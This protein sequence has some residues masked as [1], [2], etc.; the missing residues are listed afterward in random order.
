MSVRESL[1]NLRET[2]RNTGTIGPDSML[3]VM[4]ILNWFSDPVSF[5][6]DRAT[7]PDRTANVFLNG[8]KVDSVMAADETNGLV[9]RVAFDSKGN[10]MLDGG[11]VMSV[12]QYGNVRIV[13][14][15]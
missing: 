10:V 1:R 6:L 4:T 8:T 3:D 9:V 7:G 15:E 11:H 5:G 14:K 2:V 12:T 13:P